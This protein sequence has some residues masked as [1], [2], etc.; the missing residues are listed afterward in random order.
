MKGY[1][2]R[3]LA[4]VGGEHDQPPSTGWKFRDWDTKDYD[5]L[6]T[7]EWGVDETVSCQVFVNTPPCCLTVSLSG[8]A[9]EVQGQCEGEY[10]STGLVSAGRPVM[11]L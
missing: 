7:R 1:D 8:A 4:S 11:I 5:T 2:A 10:K 6:T 9:K 3:L